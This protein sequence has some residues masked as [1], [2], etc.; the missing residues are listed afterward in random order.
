MT[1]GSVFQLWR[2]PVKSM[3]GE[4][5]IAARFG[6]HG[7]V[8]DRTHALFADRDGEFRSVT[9]RETPALLAWKATYPFAP[10]GSLKPT[11]PVASVSAPTQKSWQWGDPRLKHTLEDSL[12]RAVTLRRDPVAG[13]HD[14]GGTVLVTVEA[15]R[16][17][18]EQ[19]LGSTLDIRRF[20]P[21][22]H[23]E[24]DCNP[25]DEFGWE[26]YHLRFSGGVQLKLTQVCERCVITTRDV[27]TQEKWPELMDRLHD[28]HAQRFGI[29]GVVHIAG[30]MEIGERAEL[31]PATEV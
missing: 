9:A 17:A 26:G 13:F 22:V 19:E 6:L 10:D 14:V 23:V 8:G 16:A 29:Y 27:R 3:A 2:Y 31:I 11:P 28:D 5:L 24:L 1:T 7:V 18:F 12:G 20:R 4:R 15:T 21:N 30:R 25:W